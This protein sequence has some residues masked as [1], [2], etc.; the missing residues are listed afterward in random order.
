MQN[1]TA[2]YNYIYNSKIILNNHQS[3]LTETFTDNYDLILPV[4]LGPEINITEIN[5]GL[6]LKPM[7]DII[8][9]AQLI[10]LEKSFSNY[11]D[12]AYILLGKA[13]FFNGNYFN[14]AEYFDYVTKTYKHNQGIFLE[15][16]NWKARSLMQLKRLS[17][18]NQVLD[19]LDSILPKIKAKKNLAEPL[20]TMAQ[21]CIYLN[22]DTAAIYYLKRAVKAS[23][24]NQSKTRWTFILAQLYE[25]QENYKEAAANYRKVQKSNAP[26]EMY[27]HANLNLIK[28][29]TL[30]NDNKTDR[31]KQLL[32]L[33]KDDKNFD[34]NDQIYFQ[35][36]ES[37]AADQEFQ[38]ALKYYLL[39]VQKSNTD[40]N[41][42]GLSYLRLA[43]L[44]FKYFKDY[45][46]AKSYYD[47]TVNTLP[48]NYPG[49][50]LIL[51]KSNNLKYLTD[52]Y[53]LI[54]LQDSLQAIAKLPEHLRNAR[55]HALAEPPLKEKPP[56]TAGLI[57]TDFRSS[58]NSNKLQPANSFYFSNPTAVSI[59]FSD[60][61]RKWGTRKLENNW[62]QSIRKAV[63]ETAG[64]TSNTISSHLVI[65]N[66]TSPNADKE[67]L[68]KEYTASI[69]LTSA[70]IAASNQKIVDAYFEIASFYL[71]ELDDAE[72]AAAVYHTL[73]ARFPQNNHLASV[74]YSLYLI[75]KVAKPAESLNFR[76]RIL[77]DFPNSVYAKIILDPSFSLKQSAL[78][79][80][81]N[82]NYNHI[83]SL[84]EKKDFASVI[85]Q[86]DQAIASGN[87]NLLLP[88]IAYLKAIAI[89]RTNN[90]DSLLAAFNSITASFPE[91]KLISPL[92]KEHIDY[93]I[94]HLSEFQKR[95]IALIDFDPNEPQFSDPVRP[96]TTT[97][98]SVTQ[99]KPA[100]IPDAIKTSPPDTTPL[101]T[102]V[103]AQAPEPQKIAPSVVTDSIFT[104]DAST[105]YYFVVH[106]AD[107][108]LTL[109]SSRFGIGQFNRV[110][111]NGSNLK[112][113]L[114]EFDN[115]QLIFV[116]NF[117]NF[118]DVKYYAAGITPQLK[119]IMKVPVNIY[120]SFIISKENFD[121]L[122][123]RD[124]LNRYLE[125]Y[126]NNY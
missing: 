27:F 110:N 88:Q 111:Y 107:A 84:Y 14:A 46:L 83:F 37:Y 50:D 65:T 57:S 109:S 34:Y 36:A 106:V 6:D 113:Q 31:Y 26:F 105:V 20:A 21:M 30:Q 96:G 10:V 8:K 68:I 56:G 97:P 42:K 5:S 38:E 62:R 25:K 99:R 35:I 4:Y 117:S 29:Q 19:T 23:G 72:E 87:A 108:A 49:Y 60:F 119:Q 22:K 77:K 73:L 114:K 28:L 15:A 18:A 80:E 58:S 120:S 67:S 112:H 69:P 7:E 64:D 3:E 78:E 40:R 103:P 116:G 89:G 121:K 55:I 76:S 59:G 94:S 13:N 74:Y 126:K 95:K 93:L 66:S 79:A 2:R 124:L 81:A 24:R 122:S 32:S 54:A 51:K 86:A 91:E 75:N 63:Q 102:A 1:L 125:F 45:L 47:S 85:K 118:E 9:K 11:T 92:V 123:N 17:E 90:V 82:N 39:A 53:E 41:H 16:V 100:I 48:K 52:R 98:L 43:D 61:K 104:K 70:S 33:L 115:D 44:N 12:D 71:Q 101:Q